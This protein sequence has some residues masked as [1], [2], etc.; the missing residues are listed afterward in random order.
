MFKDPHQLTSVHKDRRYK[1]VRKAM[2]G[3]DGKAVF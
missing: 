2:L 1:L 3:G